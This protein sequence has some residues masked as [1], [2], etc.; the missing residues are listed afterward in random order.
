VVKRDGQW[1]PVSDLISL[2]PNEETFTKNVRVRTIGDISCTGMIE[3]PVSSVRDIITE[4]SAARVT[5][6]G[7]RADDKK[8][9]TAMEDRKKEGYF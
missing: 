4:I 6:R 2:K 5:E 1:L 8:S 7:S 3:S 9:E